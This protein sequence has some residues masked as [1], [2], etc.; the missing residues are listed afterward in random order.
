M[1]AVED[2]PPVVTE[3]AERDARS[4]APVAEFGTL[5]R[6]DPPGASNGRTS[7]GIRS[8]VRTCSRTSAAS[9]TSNGPPTSG[10]TPCSRSA[11]TKVHALLD[12]VVGHQVDPGHVVAEP[13]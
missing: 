7:S 11:S 10:G 6:S 4:W 8:G 12:A 3:A 5:T 2:A 13:A 1:V 9:T